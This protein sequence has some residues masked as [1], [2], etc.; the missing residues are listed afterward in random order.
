MR[1]PP[2]RR[3]CRVRRVGRDTRCRGGGGGVGD[4]VELVGGLAVRVEGEQ[5]GEPGRR[6][7]WAG[8]SWHRPM[9][10]ALAG[11]VVGERCM[12]RAATI[13]QGSPNTIS[14]RNVI[15]VRCRLAG[16]PVTST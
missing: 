2:R 15:C 6:A 12:T 3:L 11:V 10:V 14:D 1:L 16:G 8:G 9:A 7:A 5:A 4:L 13:S